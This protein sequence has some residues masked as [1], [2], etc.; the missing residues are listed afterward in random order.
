M[1]MLAADSVK[2]LG[3]GDDDYGL[4]GKSKVGASDACGYTL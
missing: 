4:G 3:M 2:Y 1:L